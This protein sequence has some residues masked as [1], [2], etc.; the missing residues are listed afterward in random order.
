MMGGESIPRLHE[1]VHDV[2]VLIAELKA[3]H[4]A[5]PGMII[6]LGLAKQEAERKAARVRTREAEG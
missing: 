2:D 1:A 4:R 5:I 6:A 3:L